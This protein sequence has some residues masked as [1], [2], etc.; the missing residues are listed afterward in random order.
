MV[1]GLG[2]LASTGLV[3]CSGDSTESATPQASAAIVVATSTGVTSS[4]VTSTAETSATVSSTPAPTIPPLT[5]PPLTAVL[6]EDLALGPDDFANLTTMTLV[7]GF[8]ISN[9]LDH[10]DAAVAVAR[11]ERPG[12]YPVGTIIQLFPSEAM[13]KRGPGFDPASGDWEFFLLDVG[14]SGTEIVSRG[15]AEVVNGFG[16]SCVSCHSLAAPASDFVCHGDDDCPPLNLDPTAIREI[17]DADPRP[18][19]L[20]DD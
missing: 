17:Q 10:L 5:I 18:T 3:G 8:Y 19:D 14:T 2:L 12:P 11:G 4:G 7:D 15:G 9:P 20:T 1:I 16:V 6:T 13:V